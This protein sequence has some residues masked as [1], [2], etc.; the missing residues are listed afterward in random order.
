MAALKSIKYFFAGIER[1]ILVC[2]SITIFKQKIE[3]KLRKKKGMA[4]KVNRQYVVK[5]HIVPIC[6]DF[7]LSRSLITRKK[8]VYFRFHKSTQMN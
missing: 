4:L 2:Y 5:I 6:R 7:I 3:G 1:Y 8:A